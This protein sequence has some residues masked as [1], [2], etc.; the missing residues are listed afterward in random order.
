MYANPKCADV[1]RSWAVPGGAVNPL[2]SIE[3]LQAERSDETPPAVLDVRGE[4]EYR[5]GHIAGG[6]HVPADELEQR[7]AQIPKDRPVVPY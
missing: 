4:D 2:I 3:E 5:A 1:D 7:V 6:I